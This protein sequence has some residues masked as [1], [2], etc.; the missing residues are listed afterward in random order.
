MTEPCENASVLANKKTERINRNINHTQ[1]KVYNN[2]ICTLSFCNDT[3]VSMNLSAARGIACYTF[4][5]I[6]RY[7]PANLVE[8]GRSQA[9]AWALATVYEIAPRW[10]FA[11]IKFTISKKNYHI[12]TGIS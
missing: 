2:F 8:N 3:I 11:F 6:V 9:R 4:I 7:V 5:N 1:H 12:I 10:Q